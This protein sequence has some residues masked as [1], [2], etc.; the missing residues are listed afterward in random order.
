MRF[1][2]SIQAAKSN[3]SLRSTR[4]I[5]NGDAMRRATAI[6][7]VAASALVADSA[8]AKS[9]PPKVTFVSE[10]VCVQI[11]YGVDWLNGFKS[12]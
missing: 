3:A 10:C 12:S 1:V 9:T 8:L 11:L 7:L 5:E 6:F 2:F 4:R